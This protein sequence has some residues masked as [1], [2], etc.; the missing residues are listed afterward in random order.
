VS[1]ESILSYPKSKLFNPLLAQTISAFG[2]LT[3]PPL[4]SFILD[5][6][7]ISA[8]YMGIMMSS[9]YLGC[10]IFSFVTGQI[11]NFLGIQ[12]SMVLSLMIIGVF[13]M[14]STFISSIWLMILFLSIAGMGYSL[15]NP[16]INLLITQDFSKDVRGLA[17]SIKQMGVTL[18]G[19]LTALSLPKLAL[20]FDWRA[21]LFCGGAIVFCMSFYFLFIL[22]GYPTNPSSAGKGNVFLNMKVVFKNTRLVR[23]SILSFFFVGAQFSY[24]MYLILFLHLDLGYSI[25]IASGLLALSQA[26]GTVGRVIWGIVSDRIGDRR[27]VL[28]TIGIS[29]A[30]FLVTLSLSSFLSYPLIVM[31]FITMFIGFTLSGWNG[32]FQ[33]AII[34]YGGEQSAAV[35]SGVSLTFTY[36]G[37]CIFPLIFGWSKDYFSS[38]SVSWIIVSICLI[39]STSLIYE[40]KKV[41]TAIDNVEIKA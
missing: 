38:F 36:M 41:Q 6:L 1:K 37:I 22:K 17:M 29:S 23:L 34:E 25:A 12:K 31:A 7:G 28:T 11:I 39:I 27:K 18:G 35:S 15:I 24:F 13:I 40:R 8:F 10:I 19:V 21:A 33:A 2:V 14:L 30:L 3:L 9:F 16:T 5:D 20:M 26:T 4:A 32:V